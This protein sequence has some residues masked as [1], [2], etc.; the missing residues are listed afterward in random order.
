MRGRGVVHDKREHIV[1]R[2]LIVREFKRPFINRHAPWWHD[3]AWAP[4][5][6]GFSS[7][8]AAVAFKL[9]GRAAG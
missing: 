4:A 6:A 5:R 1:K 3:L 7:M 9:V 2:E 8:R